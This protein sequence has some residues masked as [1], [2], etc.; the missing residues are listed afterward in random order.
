MKNVKFQSN[1]SFLKVVQ[2]REYIQKSES[3]ISK[4]YYVFQKKNMLLLISTN[5]KLI[6]CKL[7][8]IQSFENAVVKNM[9]LIFSLLLIYSAVRLYSYRSKIALSI[10]I[11]GFLKTH[12]VTFLCTLSTGSNGG[13]TLKQ[14]NVELIFRFQ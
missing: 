14:P 4:K 9:C 1:V 6:D 13:F 2:K 10:S 11:Y 12:N 5:M 8:E 7:D 3:N